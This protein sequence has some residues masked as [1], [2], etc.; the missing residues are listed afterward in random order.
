MQNSKHVISLSIDLSRLSF[1]LLLLSFVSACSHPRKMEETPDRFEH[2][3]RSVYRVNDALDRR[4]F[5]PVAKVYNKYTPQIID[6]S[7]TN[8]FANLDD[9]G[10]AINSL[11]QFKAGEALIDTERFIFN[12]TFG[13]AGIFDIATEMGLQKHEEDFGQ[14]LAKWGVPSGPY[15]MLPLL[16]PSTIRDATAKLSVDIVTKPTTYSK[17]SWPL[18]VVDKLDQRANLLSA[19]EVLK[20]FSDD[21]YSVLRGVWLQ[22]R[23]HLIRDG[24]VDEDAQSDMIDELE[25]LDAE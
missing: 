22:R 20:V 24:K 14:T 21:Q 3:N 13:I 19:E 7:I 23:E 9:V 12:S 15:I 18:L 8:V 6:T 1:I 16:G 10:N 4:L 17:Y 2:L 5:K 25:D 11:L